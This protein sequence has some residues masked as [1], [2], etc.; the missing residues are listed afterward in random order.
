[1]ESHTEYHNIS[2]PVLRIVIPNSKP[3]KEKAPA[4]KQSKY[5]LLC[6]P[7][8][9]TEQPKK[10][11]KIWSYSKLQDYLCEFDEIEE[12][13]T[14]ITKIQS[15]L[16]YLE[17][18]LGLKEKKEDSHKYQEN[19]KR[20]TQLFRVLLWQKANWPNQCLPIHWCGLSSLNG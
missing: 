8:Q 7:S 4:Y 12:V 14:E 19:V 9:G 2:T 3:V 11:F 16:Q 6:P 10:P 13:E 17:G 20:C 15:M 1:M 5:I 18:P